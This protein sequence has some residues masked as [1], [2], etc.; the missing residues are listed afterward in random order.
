LEEEKMSENINTNEIEAQVCEK[1]NLAYAMDMLEKILEDKEHILLALNTIVA[2]DNEGTPCGGSADKAAMA[3]MEIVKSRE[4]TNQ[5][6]IDF[7]SKMVDDIKK[8][9]RKTELL[10]ES[11]R[12]NRAEFLKFVQETTIATAGAS[13]G[14]SP[15]KLPDF[16]DLWKLLYKV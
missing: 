4:A 16:E 1:Y 8:E 7:Y 15:A 9:Q 6:L 10:S 3:A 13:I 12:Q 2:L 5:K 14:P 11:D